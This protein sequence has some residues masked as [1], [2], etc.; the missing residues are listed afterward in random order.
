MSNI[1]QQLQTAA[2][3]AT[4]PQA[5]MLSDLAAKFQNAEQTGDLSQLKQT[6][7]GRHHHHKGGAGA[8]LQNSASSG[9]SST[10]SSGSTSTQSQ[11][12]DMQSL[13][14]NIF[15]EVSQALGS[16]SGS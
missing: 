14:Q 2:Q 5:K 11:G 1:V 8:V 4:G 9:T 10:T 15:R 12:V 13:F 6:G 7:G 16:G 3:N